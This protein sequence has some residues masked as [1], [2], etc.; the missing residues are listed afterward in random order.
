ME[1]R[2]ERQTDWLLE[3]A[4]FWG[5]YNADYLGWALRPVSFR[6]TDSRSELGRWLS[7]PRVIEISAWHVRAAPWTEVMVTLRH[8]MA[9]QYVDEVLRVADETAHG[10]AFRHACRLLRVDP[11]ASGALAGSGVVDPQG[12]RVRRL[13]EKLLALGDSPNENEATAAMRKARHLMLEHNVEVVRPDSDRRFVTRTLGR[14]QKR[15]AGWE[16]RLGGL[17]AEFFFVET[18]WAPDYDAPAARSGK[19]LHVYGTPANVGMAEYVHAYLSGVVQELWKQWKRARKQRSDQGRREYLDGVLLGFRDKLRAQAK[20]FAAA[21]SAL[22][23]RGDPRLTKHYRWHNP[24]VRSLG[25]RTVALTEAHVAGRAAGREVE[26]R[27][28]L[29]GASSSHGGLLPG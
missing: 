25:S 7:G 29:G 6:L 20:E 21:G 15:H 23:W 16:L 27:R 14:V 22:I 24:R 5:A 9:H 2:E 17:L 1:S 4:R 12:D 8:E 28:P 19:S 3:L 10:A 13:V 18:I 11:S 26:L